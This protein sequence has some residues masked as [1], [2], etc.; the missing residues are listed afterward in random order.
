MEVKRNKELE[1]AAADAARDLLDGGWDEDQASEAIADIADMLVDWRKV[2]PGALG[3]MVEQ[4]DGQVIADVLRLVARLFEKDPHA[5]IERLEKK[6]AKATSSGQTKKAERIHARLV[7]V[8]QRTPDVT[9]M[10]R[11]SDQL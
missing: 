7:R 9:L 8:I 6:L 11:L 1:R 4:N 2:L 10:D 3:E 5:R